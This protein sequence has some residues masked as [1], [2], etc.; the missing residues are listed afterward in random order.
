[1]RKQLQ[2]W[3]TFGKNIHKKNSV[4]KKKKYIICLLDYSNIHHQNYSKHKKTWALKNNLLSYI[5]YSLVNHIQYKQQFIQTNIIFNYK[6]FLK[7]STLVMNYFKIKFGNKIF[8]R[9]IIYNIL[10]RSKMLIKQSKIKG[11]RFFVNGKTTS[12]LRNRP[13]TKSLGNLNFNTI[14]N[15]LDYT[16]FSIS[17]KEGSIGIKIWIL[18]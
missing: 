18:F 10:R 5:S 7:S 2:V 14:T 1:M 16:S 12:K 15:K 3:Y 11:I 8:F 9:K 13:F 4:V 17:S 6:K